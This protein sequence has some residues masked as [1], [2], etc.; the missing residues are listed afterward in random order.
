M[1]TT[2]PVARQRKFKTDW[3]EI[4]YLYH[5]LLYW[6]YDREDT[7][8]ALSFGNRL[9]RLVERVDPG[10]EAILG[11]ECRSLIS[12]AKG[13][14]PNA[15]RYRENEIRMMKRLQ[16]IS[17][18]Y[19]PSTREYMLRQRGYDD[20]SDRLD[21]LAILYHDSGDLDRAIRTLRDSKRFCEKHEIP[22]DGQD[23]LEDYLGEKRGG[24]NGEP[25][26]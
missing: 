3:D 1:K 25:L 24:A 23:L 13:D 18:A 21:L 14:L 26:P 17:I 4:V 5:K 2:A 11:Q 7:R 15:I 20:L 9:E 10:H 19:D 6:L 22:F 16:Q 8:K 12:E